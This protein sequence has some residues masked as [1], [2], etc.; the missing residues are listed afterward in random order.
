[1]HPDSSLACFSTRRR[2][3]CLLK[4]FLITEKW[5]LDSDVFSRSIL[6]CCRGSKCKYFMDPLWS[7]HTDCQGLQ[8][9]NS[10]EIK[11]RGTGESNHFSTSSLRDLSSLTHICGEKMKTPHPI[12]QIHMGCEG[13]IQATLTLRCL[14][15]ALQHFIFRELTVYKRKHRTSA[16]ENRRKMRSSLICGRLHRHVTFGLIRLRRQTSLE[17]S[18]N[19]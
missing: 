12:W 16:V 7:F 4:V 6:P 15:V 19:F 14:N 17:L 9:L 1:M 8:S 18:L 11:K 13:C 5:A 2:F 10:P 3:V